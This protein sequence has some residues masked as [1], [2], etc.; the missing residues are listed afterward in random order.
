MGG[1]TNL[2]KQNGGILRGESDSILLYE[3]NMAKEKD[4]WWRK[5]DDEEEEEAEDDEDPWDKRDGEGGREGGG[6]RQKN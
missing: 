3:N 5:D 6:V 4:W 2:S 1:S